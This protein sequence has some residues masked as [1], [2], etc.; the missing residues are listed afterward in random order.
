MLQNILLQVTEGRDAHVHLV[1]WSH[2]DACGYIVT[3]LRPVQVVPEALTK[4]LNTDLHNGW[5]DK[6]SE[7]RRERARKVVLRKCNVCTINVLNQS[8]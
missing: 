1:I 2:D 7:E 8:I 5:K 6:Q 3:D 4:P